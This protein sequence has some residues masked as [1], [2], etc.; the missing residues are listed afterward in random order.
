MSIIIAIAVVLLE[1]S[2][3]VALCGDPLLLRN[4][5]W[6]GYIHLIG[7]FDWSFIIALLIGLV[8]FAPF[9]IDVIFQS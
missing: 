5:D 1:K 2:L 9:L 4:T 7:F 6:I 8:L 3:L